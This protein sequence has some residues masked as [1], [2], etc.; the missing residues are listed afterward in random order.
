M[1]FSCYS[2][3]D[4]A[5]NKSHANAVQ[6]IINMSFSCGHQQKSAVKKDRKR[7]IIIVSIAIGWVST[8]HPQSHIL[9]E[10]RCTHGWISTCCNVISYTNMERLNI[11]NSHPSWML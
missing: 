10:C 5:I 8:Y 11:N 7:K 1:F 9:V 6:A 4:V 2:S 3:L